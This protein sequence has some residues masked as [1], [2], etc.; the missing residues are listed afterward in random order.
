MFS[1]GV[2]GLPGAAEVG[3][4]P[5]ERDVVD[6]VAG[7]VAPT[8][9]PGPSRSS[10][11]RRA[12]GCGRRQSSGPAPSRSI[13][14]GRN[15]SIRA[16][17]RS[18]RSSSTPTP[19]GCLRSTAR[20]RRP[21]SV[22]S[23]CGVSGCRAAHRLRPLDA[24]DLGAHVGEQHRGERSGP[25]AGDLDDAVAGERAGARLDMR[26]VTPTIADTISGHSGGAGRGPCR[27]PAGGGRRGSRRRSPCRRSG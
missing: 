12:A 10:A 15:P 16:S 21:R 20:L 6:V 2:G 18:T 19:S 13:T 5:G 11:R 14:P 25:D 3:E 9:R 4:R 27:R 26:A 8:A 7:G 17:A 22:T 1:G 23:T 24:D